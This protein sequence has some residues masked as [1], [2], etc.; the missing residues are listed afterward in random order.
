MTAVL[1]K[2]ASEAE[3]AE[4]ETRV[5]LTCP[6]MEMSTHS[7]SSPLLPS[8]EVSGRFSFLYLRVWLTGE[9]SDPR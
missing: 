7:A 3:R 6:R 2:A 4:K 1:G 8:W 5:V 9:V